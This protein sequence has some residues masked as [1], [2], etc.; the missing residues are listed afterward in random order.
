MTGLI[1][2]GIGAAAYFHGLGR[3]NLKRAIEQT[4]TSKA[5]AV[6]PG[7]AEVNGKARRFRG[8]LTSPLDRQDC[9]YFHTDI[10]AWSG[11]GK[12]RKRSRVAT[13]ESPDP[14]LIE[15]DTGSVLVHVRKDMLRKDTGASETPGRGGIAGFFLGQKEHGPNDRVYQM[16]AQYAPK[17]ANYGDRIDV[18]ETYVKEGD[19]L[20]CIGTAT[21][22][23]PEVEKEVLDPDAKDDVYE[24]VATDARKGVV[25]APRM[26]IRNDSSRRIY[27]VSDGTERDAVNAVGW[28][29]LFSAWGGPLLV[30]IGLF[31]LFAQLDL[32]GWM[33]AVAVAIVVMVVFALYAWL[34]LSG[35]LWLYNGLVALR[36]GVDRAR[37]NIDA[38]LQKRAD[39]IPQLVEVTKAYAAHETGLFET[40]AVARSDP[41]TRASAS[42]IALEEKY[43][44]LKA[45]ETFLPLQQTLAKL[46][47]HIAASRIYYNDSVE[48]YNAKIG[49]IPYNLIAAAANMRPIPYYEFKA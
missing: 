44:D 22:Y 45:S 48:L 29:A 17:Y 12:H 23:L 20:Y 14:I 8:L 36:T 9:I 10:Y 31:V 2:A 30:G 3:Y 16:L 41:A 18:D 32:G 43:P 46:E 24:S 26:I 49:K 11:S 5:V 27:C 39:L 1:A 47:E 21:E 28:D 42:F 38:M 37:A 34:A 15:D 40:I 13:L 19:P 35:L 7:I 6:A 25:E 33:A 4:P